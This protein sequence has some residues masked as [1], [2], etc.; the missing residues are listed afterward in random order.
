MYIGEVDAVFLEI[1]LPFPFIPSESHAFIIHINMRVTRLF[2]SQGYRELRPIIPEW[3]INGVCVYKVA[4]T[5]CKQP[6]HG[7]TVG[8]LRRDGF[9][10]KVEMTMRFHLD[11][12]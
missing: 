1:G 7:S 8:G 2:P 10:P 6:T 12:A 11:R 5:K 3:D 9:P 4:K